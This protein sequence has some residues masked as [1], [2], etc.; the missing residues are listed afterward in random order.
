MLPKLL[1]IDHIHVYCSSR[2]RAAT[3]YVEELGFS[4][5]EKYKFWAEDINGP[6]TLESKT[7]GI[8]I[9]LFQRSNFVPASVLALGTTGSEFLKWKQYLTDKKLLVSCKDHTKSWSLYFNDGD[10]NHIEITTYDHEIVRDAMSKD[11]K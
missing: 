4:V 10:E 6:L 8:H 2:E 3:W 7:G 5:V 11:F 9:A 1:G